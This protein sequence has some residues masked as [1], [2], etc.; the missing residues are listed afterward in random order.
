MITKVERTLIF[1]EGA[2]TLRIPPEGFAVLSRGEGAN[3]LRVPRV[4]VVA[5]L[6]TLRDLASAVI[7]SL[8]LQEVW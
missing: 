8:N 2:F 7:E 4:D 3:E 1:E 5:E 6:A